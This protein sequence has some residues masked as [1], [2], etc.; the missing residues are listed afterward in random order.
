MVGVCCVL[1][2]V[3]LPPLKWSS[4]KYDFG[5]GGTGNGK[6]KAYGGRDRHETETGRCADR[7]GAAGGGGRAIDR[8]NGSY[9]LSV[10]Q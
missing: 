2:D 1:N 4:L 7:P 3:D 9:V 5:E 10:A 8:G 6:E